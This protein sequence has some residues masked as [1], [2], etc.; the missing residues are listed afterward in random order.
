[1]FP[2]TITHPAFPTFHVKW[3]SA[4]PQ[5]VPGIQLQITTT[6]A[7]CIVDQVN[8]GHCTSEKESYYGT[9]LSIEVPSEK[10]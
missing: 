1:M 10:D 8:K 4:A 3:G 7:V 5:K 2:S 6:G 9:S